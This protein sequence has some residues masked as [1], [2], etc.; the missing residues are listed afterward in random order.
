VT[1]VVTVLALAGMA[2]VTAC[3]VLILRVTFGVMREQQR[4]APPETRSVTRGLTVLVVV[5]MAGAFAL[6][7]AEP[8]GSKTILVAAGGGGLVM[9][10]GLAIMLRVFRPRA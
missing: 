1:L 9:A 2:A 4:T 8:W 6:A 5:L 10:V 3:T 7:I